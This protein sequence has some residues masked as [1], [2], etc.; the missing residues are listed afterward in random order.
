MMFV[1]RISDQRQISELLF[2]IAYKVG[3]LQTAS[4]AEAG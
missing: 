4:Y 2:Q 1:S 3:Q